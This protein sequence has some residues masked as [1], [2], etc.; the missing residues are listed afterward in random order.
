MR[1]VTMRVWTESLYREI[2]EDNQGQIRPDVR[3]GRFRASFRLEPAGK[4]TAN[5][6]V[7]QS[8]TISALA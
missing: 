4:C 6:D 1:E 3:M 2:W 5:G 8:V 7:E